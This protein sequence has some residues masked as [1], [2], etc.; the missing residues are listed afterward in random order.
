MFENVKLNS[1]VYTNTFKSEEKLGKCVKGFFSNFL[2]FIQILILIMKFYAKCVTPN[3][4]I[5]YMSNGT[6]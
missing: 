6:E 5:L 3:I 1:S 2:I 4:V